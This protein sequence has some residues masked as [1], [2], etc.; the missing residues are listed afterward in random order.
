MDKLLRNAIELYARRETGRQLLYGRTEAYLIQ[1]LPY[2]L[3]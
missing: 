3:D 2:G 1:N